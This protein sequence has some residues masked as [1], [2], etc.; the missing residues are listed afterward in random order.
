MAKYALIGGGKVQNIVAADSVDN[1]GPQALMY[2]A[3]DITDLEPAPSVG[4]LY[5][6][7]KT[8]AP[9]LPIDSAP[10]GYVAEEAAPAPKTTSTK[11]S[12]TTTA[13]PAEE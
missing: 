3:V 11:K 7:D 1:I 6:K 12:S 2:L 9:E 8:F 4:W 10:W 5:R 13:T